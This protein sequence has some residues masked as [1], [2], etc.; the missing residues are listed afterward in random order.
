MKT[1]VLAI[2]LVL[3]LVILTACGNT[4]YPKVLYHNSRWRFDDLDK[5]IP[6]INGYI[7][8]QANPYETIETEQG[9]NLVLHFVRGAPQ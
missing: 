9:Y 1:K 5:T 8:D 3:V 4:V 6:V 7:L 2:L